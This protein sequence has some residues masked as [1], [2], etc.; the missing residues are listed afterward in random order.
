MVSIV[1]NFTSR[2]IVG[3]PVPVSYGPYELMAYAQIPQGIEHETNVVLF[4]TLEVLFDDGNNGLNA[5]ARGVALNENEEQIRVD[6]TTLSINK[7]NIHSQFRVFKN[8]LFDK[9]NGNVNEDTE[10]HFSGY[11]INLVEL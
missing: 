6:K 5:T 11:L 3:Q 7:V 9:I 8:V 10:I 1:Q 2:Q 4:G